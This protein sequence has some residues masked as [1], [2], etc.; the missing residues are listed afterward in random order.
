MPYEE[1]G[2]GQITKLDENN[3]TVEGTLIEI[4]EGL[5]GPLFD[6]QTKD[7]ETITLPSDTVLQTKITKNF[8]GKEIKI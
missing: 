8:I 2:R 1:V 6:I 7:G 5:Y 3:P 4:R